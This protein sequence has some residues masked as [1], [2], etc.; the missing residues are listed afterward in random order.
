MLNICCPRKFFTLNQT[1]WLLLFSTD[2]LRRLILNNGNSSTLFFGKRLALR[3]NIKYSLE[4]LL[5]L[6][7]FKWS[8]PSRPTQTE[9]LWLWLPWNS[10]VVVFCFS[11][12]KQRNE[13]KISFFG[14]PML[15]FKFKSLCGRI[16]P[17]YFLPTSVWHIE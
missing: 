12:S 16:C 6:T 8:T 1:A 2:C 17:P 14:T 9:A 3:K 15:C 10:A 5:E 13:L 7:T 11:L 4:M